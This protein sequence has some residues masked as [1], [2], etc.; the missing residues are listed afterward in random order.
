MKLCQVS[1][2]PVN[3]LLLFFFVQS[4]LLYIY[5]Y[6]LLIISHQSFQFYI[7]GSTKAFLWYLC[8]FRELTVDYFL[9][10]RS[11]LAKFAIFLTERSLPQENFKLS[12]TCR[13]RFPYKVKHTYIG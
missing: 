12:G 2:L 8:G 9:Y 11:K 3:Y 5:K 1:G 13:A 4:L 6:F 10:K 7:V